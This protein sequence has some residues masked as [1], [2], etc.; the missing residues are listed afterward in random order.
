MM[1]QYRIG[2]GGRKP[3]SISTTTSKNTSKPTAASGLGSKIDDLN[4]DLFAQLDQLQ[5]STSLADI[6][7]INHPTRSLNKYER[8]A[9]IGKQVVQSQAGSDYQEKKKAY[10]KA[11]KQA[12]KKKTKKKVTRDMTGEDLAF[13]VTGVGVE[14]TEIDEDADSEDAREEFRDKVNELYDVDDEMDQ[15]MESV[16]K[17][18]KEDCLRM[19]DVCLLVIR[20]RR[21][22]LLLSENCSKRLIKN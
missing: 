9:A 12:A 16:L 6:D 13:F 20:I 10:E 15:L 19:K 17:E 2:S 1:K 14:Q 8:L 5:P 4:S 18:I 22:I 11:Q 3:S 21:T 7:G